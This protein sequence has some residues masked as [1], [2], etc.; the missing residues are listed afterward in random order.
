MNLEFTVS[1]TLVPSITLCIS[2]R[3]V[4][5]NCHAVQEIECTFHINVFFFYLGIVKN[6]FFS[7]DISVRTKHTCLAAI[8]IKIG[9]KQKPCLQLPPSLELVQTPQPLSGEV[10]YQVYKDIYLPPL[11]NPN[12]PKSLLKYK[13]LISFLS[14]KETLEILLI[15]V[16]NFFFSFCFVIILSKYKHVGIGAIRGFGSYS[17]ANNPSPLRVGI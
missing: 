10:V 17:L 6:T 12:P 8:Y 4:K 7:A 1:S 5:I 16:D 9:I 11:R 3:N 2:C 15:I 14:F 13:F